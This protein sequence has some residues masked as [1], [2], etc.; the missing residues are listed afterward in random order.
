MHAC[1]DALAQRVCVPTHRDG[2]DGE[3]LSR[4]GGVQFEFPCRF[5]IT[6][7]TELRSNDLAAMPLVACRALRHRVRPPR[8]EASEAR[9][10]V[11]WSRDTWRWSAPPPGPRRYPSRRSAAADGVAGAELGALWLRGGG[12]VPRSRLVSSFS[13]GARAAR[14]DSASSRLRGDKAGQPRSGGRCKS[15]LGAAASREKQNGT[16]RPQGINSAPQPNRQPGTHNGLVRARG[17]GAAH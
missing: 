8:P 11:V 16:G 7:G 4:R 15:G 5:L 13:G 2:R 10:A 6:R 17:R 12:R 14:V 9:P 1:A 3:G